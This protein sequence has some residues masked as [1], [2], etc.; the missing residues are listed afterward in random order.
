MTKIVDWM[1][2]NKLAEEIP[3]SRYKTVIR[4]TDKGKKLVNL[5]KEI[6]SLLG[7]P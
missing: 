6:H 7:D 4:L 5:I 3:V 1:M 2:E